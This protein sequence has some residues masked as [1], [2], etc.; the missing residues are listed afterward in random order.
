DRPNLSKD[1]LAGQAPEAWL[2]LAPE[3][4]YSER[5]ITLRL[6]ARVDRLD[7]DT[8]TLHLADGSTHAF[9]A[10]LLAT[11]ADPIRPAIPGADLPHVHLLRSLSDCRRIMA[12]CGPGRRAVVVGASFIGMETAA[13]LQVRGVEVHVVA[14]DAVPFERSLGAAL[15]ERLQ[16]AHEA[17]GTTFHLGQRPASIDVQA[18]TLT[19]GTKLPADLVV[20]GI[21]VR[22]NTTLAQSL[23][24]AI[25]R[26][27]V[28]D[29]YLETTVPGVFAA[30]DNAAWL[31]LRTQT[32][33]HAEH[34]VVAQRQGQTAALNIL[35]ERR[36]FDAVPFF[37]TVQHD[38][39]VQY[40][41]YSLPWDRFE[42]RGEPAD[43]DC[44]VAY[45]R[46]ATLVA[47]ATIGRPRVN[48]ACEGA[49]Q[50]GDLSALHALLST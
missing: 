6:G 26:G 28:V 36:P 37:W 42:L 23:G 32:H 13:A 27:I 25:D 16:R 50:R 47:V 8:R 46:G 49:L 24:V 17:K 29:P 38:V 41:G 44:A 15:G 3:A 21:G 30:G 48:L 22:P 10:L 43:N 2:P 11:G 4:F 14:P 1:Y 19:D 33:H 9:D 31:D 34:W 18:V 20:V 35:G 39:A 7:G 40:V 45:Y 5:S 12:A